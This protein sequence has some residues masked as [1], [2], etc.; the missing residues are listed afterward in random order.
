VREERRRHP[1]LHRTPHPRPGL[2]A[3][4]FFGGEP[5]A[6]GALL[7]NGK[8][9][10]NPKAEQTLQPGDLIELFMPEGGGYGP[11]AER[12]PALRERDRLEGYVAP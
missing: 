7:I 5:G 10:A 6:T 4:G 9:P 1:L 12:D 8:A 11:P 3:Q 2:T